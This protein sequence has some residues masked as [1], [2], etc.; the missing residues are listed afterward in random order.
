MISKEK[1]ETQS[2]IKNTKLLGKFVASERYVDGLDHVFHVLEKDELFNGKNYNDYANLT[3]EE[4]RSLICKKVK[5][6]LEYDFPIDSFIDRANSMIA[7]DHQL[8]R[9]INSGVRS[10]E[11]HFY[12]PLESTTQISL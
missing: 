2:N 1:M 11:V 6:L 5:R 12:T 9:G 10:F 7:T 3:M 4:N 8:R